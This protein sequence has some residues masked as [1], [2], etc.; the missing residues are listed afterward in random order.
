MI[1]PNI[2][3]FPINID[4]NLRVVGIGRAKVQELSLAKH[5]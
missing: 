4:E 3:H 2:R 1:Q 5:L